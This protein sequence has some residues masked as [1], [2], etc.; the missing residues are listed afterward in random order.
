MIASFLS[1]SVLRGGGVIFFELSRLLKKKLASFLSV[2]L[3][4]LIHRRE[5]R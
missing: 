3:T 2:F 4:P 1:W 5:E